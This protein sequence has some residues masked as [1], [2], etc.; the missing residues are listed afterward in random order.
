MWLRDSV[1]Q[2]S[3]PRLDQLDDP[4]FFPY[5]YGQALWVYL[6][7]RFGDDVVAKSLRSKAPGGAIGVIVAVTGVDSKSLSSAWHEF[8]RGAVARPH[9]ASPETSTSAATVLGRGKSADSRLSVGPTLSPDGE[10]IAFF[11][12]RSQH[13][14]D[15]VVADTRTGAV[16]RRVVNTE[17][18]AHFESLQ[19]I[20]SAGAWSPDGRLLAMAALSGGGPVLTILNATSGSVEREVLLRQADQVFNP[21]W[22]PDG[23][24][25]AFSVLHKG[26]SDLEVVDLETATVRSFTSDAFADLH[27]AWSP[28]GRTLAFSTDRFTSSLETLTF[29]EFRLASIDVESG[30]ITELPSIPGAKNIDPHWARDGASLYF[31]SDPDGIEQRLSRRPDRW[32]D[33]QGHR[34][35]H[36]RQRGHGAQPR[37][38]RSRTRESARIQRLS[39]RCVRNSR[40]GRHGRFAPAPDVNCRGRPE[41][42]R[43]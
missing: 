9:S 12:D 32:I 25:I 8:I 24:R 40:R 21:T 1:E 31:V 26:F 10:A 13:S 14:I 15:M 5:R 6:A 29:G 43:P 36:G 42:V 28:D 27:P 37:T 4:S 30:T 17:G 22:S 2:D 33:L 39:P 18:D 38:C 16:R 23:R 34:R 7:G 20:E 3:L 11:S 41:S 19:F 35:L